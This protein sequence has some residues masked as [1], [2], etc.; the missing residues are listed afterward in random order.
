MAA[1]TRPSSV[2]DPYF[3][4]RCALG[5][6]IGF[7]MIEPLMLNPGMVLPAMLVSLFCGQRGLYSPLGSVVTAVML[8]GLIWLIF[9]LCV[10]TQGMPVV[11]FL[12]ILSVCYGAFYL[13]LRT[14]NPLGVMLLIFTTMISVMF[15]Q[16]R[17][18]AEAMR[19]AFTVTAGVSALLIPLLNLLLPPRSDAAVPPPPPPP[20]IQRLGPQALLR[21]IVLAPVLLAF[22]TAAPPSG[23]I[24]LI[25]VGLVLA[26]PTREARQ[27][28]GTG[29]D[30]FNCARRRGGHDH[31]HLVHLADAFSY[32]GAARAFGRPPL[33]HAHG[34]WCMDRCDVGW[35]RMTP[36]AFPS[37]S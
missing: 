18:A 21:L 35:A 33:Y 8:A 22:L 30:R 1:A 15:G 19:D 29:A 11:P 12:V 25:I 3:S 34:L 32:T 9:A 4:L 7:V 36:G 5:I 27:T 10:L 37:L 13:L 28:E 2:D 24:F 16:S 6:T 23:L 17:V 20:S 14:D 26:Y 31:P